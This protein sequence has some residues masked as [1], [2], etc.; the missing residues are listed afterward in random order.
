MTN[1]IRNWVTRPAGGVAAVFALTIVLAA[2]GGGSKTTTAPTTSTTTNSRSAGL[3]AFDACMKS[4]GVT[5][6][7]GA[8]GFGFGGGGGRRGTGTTVAGS[9]ASSV[10]RTFPST[11][12]PAGV[13]SAQYSA[14]IAAC[15]S[16]LPARGAG[17]FGGVN[18]AALATYRNCLNGYLTANGGTTIPTAAGGGGGFGGGFGG[19]GFGGAGTTTPGETTTTNPLMQAAQAHCVA[20]RPTFGTTTTTTP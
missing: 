6:P 12:L 19:G 5:L 10:P 8:G 4:H 18:S 9:P 7:A 2:C 17:G 14:A 13:T 1:L 11:T 20:L 15:R 16:T 3:A